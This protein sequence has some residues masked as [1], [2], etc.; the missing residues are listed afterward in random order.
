MGN[1]LHNAIR[2]INR[3]RKEAQRHTKSNPT[4]ACTLLEKAYAV[5]NGLPFSTRAVLVAKARILHAWAYCC[6]MENQLDTALFYVSQATELFQQTAEIDEY[7]KA[8]TLMQAIHSHK[9][10]Y[11][12][13]L[14][15]VQ[16]CLQL[17]HKTTN[18]RLIGQLYSNAGALLASLD[19]MPQAM[20]HFQQALFIAEGCNNYEGVCQARTNIALIHSESGKLLPAL[21]CLLQV[22]PI[23]ERVAFDRE[24]TLGNVLMRAGNTLRLL[25]SYDQALAYLLHSHDLLEKF[26]SRIEL[27]GVCT[28]IGLVYFDKND[29][30]SATAYLLRALDSHN[31]ANG[32]QQMGLN[33]RMVLAQV[34]LARGN[35]TVARGYA[36]EALHA[37]EAINDKHGK[38]GSLAIVAETYKEQG[39]YTTA[40][41]YYQQSMDVDNTESN[42]H[43]SISTLTG[44]GS[45]LAHQQYYTEALEHLHRARAL[46]EQTDAKPLLCTVYEA[47][48]STYE[49]AD[50]TKRA[51]AYFKLFHAINEEMFNEKAEQHMQVLTIL[52]NVE[53]MEKENALHKQRAEQLQRGVEQSQQALT[54]HALHLA[55][56]TDLLQK[57]KGEISTLLTQ[58]MSALQQE[59][60]RSIEMLADITPRPRKQGVSA[61]EKT[62][63]RVMGTLIAVEQEMLP[64]VHKSLQSIGDRFDSAL[65]DQGM[66]SAFEQQFQQLHSG[67]METLVQRYPQLS[68]T[69]VKVCALLKMNMSSKE[70][71]HILNVSLR[72]VE[73]YRYNIRKKLGLAAQHSLAQCIAELS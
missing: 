64:A 44:I 59:V 56:Q 4:R 30:S 36:L 7:I 60:R 26:G 72:S 13:A 55:Q 33:S 10:E 43:A 6:S 11:A 52:H 58:Q 17:E 39:D 63:H 67:F 15:L 65:L 16:S 53:H 2:T 5:A 68:T 8:V 9:G 50:D 57:A 42:A 49:Q 70:I 40:R 31:G 46:A 69:E 32:S 14:E 61:K 41:A 18:R 35:A 24:R 29:Y 3:L 21:E 48:A 20:Q 37:S 45:T 38:S 54:V 22:L 12:V 66:W 62:L 28:Y 34:E 51:L 71:G 23:A 25:G 47:L 1:T 19:S 27:G 73:T